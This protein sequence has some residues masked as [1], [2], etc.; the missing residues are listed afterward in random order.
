MPASPCLLGLL[1]LLR[2]AQ[3]QHVNFPGRNR[4]GQAQQMPRIL[5]HKNSWKIHARYLIQPIRQ[6]TT[7]AHRQRAAKKSAEVRSLRAW[8][9]SPPTLVAS[10]SRTSERRDRL[11]Q[12]AMQRKRQRAFYSGLFSTRPTEGK[13]RKI[14]WE[15]AVTHQLPH[16][17]T[18]QHQAGY[19][20]R[21]ADWSPESG[22]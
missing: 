13:S 17:A 7:G 16:G 22:Q 18:G 6:R 14:P 1:S 12:K 11:L 21:L 3:E 9:L 4:S 2:G 10:P 15:K 5:K 8:E 19:L 20:G